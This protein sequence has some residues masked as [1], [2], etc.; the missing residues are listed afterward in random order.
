MP[1]KPPTH[2]PSWTGAPRKPYANSR[3]AKQRLTGRA[4]QARNL[5]IKQRDKYTCQA[6]GRVTEDGEVDHRISLASGGGEDDL[7]LQW[8]CRTPCHADKTARENGQRPKREVGEDG[9]PVE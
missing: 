3:T 2:R 6:C 9:W 4:L 1:T 5:R 7:N 8:L